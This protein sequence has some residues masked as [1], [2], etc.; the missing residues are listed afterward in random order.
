MQGVVPGFDL[1]QLVELLRIHRGQNL[2][3]ADLKFLWSDSDWLKLSVQV[4]LY[5]IMQR[6]PT[7]D[8]DLGFEEQ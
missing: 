1:P 8:L 5:K 3:N 4:P 6:N 2:L 7:Q